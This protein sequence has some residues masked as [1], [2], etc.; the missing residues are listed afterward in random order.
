MNAWTTD[1]TERRTFTSAAY[2]A[3][4]MSE[5]DAAQ[6]SLRIRQARKDA[7]YRSRSS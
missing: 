4:L 7:G 1:G 2:L 3:G 6:I 5:M